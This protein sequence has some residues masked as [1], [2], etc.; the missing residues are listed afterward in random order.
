MW[1]EIRPIRSSAPATAWVHTIALFQ[2][3]ATSLNFAAHAQNS[4]LD[5]YLM[6]VVEG[7]F[8][9]FYRKLADYFP[10]SKDAV[11][12]MIAPK[13][14]E[15]FRAQVADMGGTVVLA[16]TLEELEAANLPP[17][18]EC[19]WNHTTLQAL[20]SEPHDWF[21]LQVAYPRPFDPALVDRQLARYG[22]EVLFHHEMAQMDGDVQI[23]ALP[24]VRW[25]SK[26][27]MYDIIHEMEQI[28]GCTVFDPH[29]ITIEDG[30]MKEIDTS[31]I[32][33]KKEADPY[34]LMNPG[35]TRS[36]TADMAR[37]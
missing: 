3:Y 15:T 24:L 14:M 13:A 21:Y 16:Q 20:K 11:F 28:D 23:F 9:P 10:A 7:R 1:V 8:A 33:F 26:E 34:G 35:K 19:G 4:D 32:D 31:Q 6:T 36:W 17:T 22:D 27:R 12:S 30:D 5:A 2:N 29:A 25:T 37:P 18:W